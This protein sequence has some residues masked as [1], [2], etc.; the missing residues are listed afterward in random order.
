MHDRRHTHRRCIG[1]GVAAA[2]GLTAVVAA[3]GVQASADAG[4][5]ATAPGGSGTYGDITTVT[6]T[7]TTGMVIVLLSPFATVPCGGD[8]AGRP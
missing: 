4:F 5:T 7:C 8:Q 6:T 2:L 1:V 3:P